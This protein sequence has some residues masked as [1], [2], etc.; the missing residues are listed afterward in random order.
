MD[1]V[2]VGESCRGGEGAGVSVVFG[3]CCIAGVLEAGEG[4]LI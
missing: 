4:G 3:G 2:R 1:L